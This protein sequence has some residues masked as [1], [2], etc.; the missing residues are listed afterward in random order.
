MEPAKSVK[1]LKIHI[2]VKLK[3]IIHVDKVYAKACMDIFVVN[4]L[5]MNGLANKFLLSI[6]QELV[7]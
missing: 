6:Y 5:K 3:G 1:I 7:R 4:R 2:T